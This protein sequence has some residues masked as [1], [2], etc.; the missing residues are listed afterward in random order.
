MVILGSGSIVAP[1]AQAGL[2]DSY[3]FVMVP[4]VLGQGRTMFQGVEGQLRLA[5]TSER[6]FKNGNVVVGYEPKR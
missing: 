4:V 5:R 3:Q 6:A 1:L 2:I